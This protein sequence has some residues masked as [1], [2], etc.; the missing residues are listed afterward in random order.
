MGRALGVIA[1]FSYQRRFLITN[2]L[3][4]GLFETVSYLGAVAI[5]YIPETIF[6][7][8]RLFCILIGDGCAPVTSIVYITDVNC[9]MLG[10]S[11]TKW[12]REPSQTLLLWR[13]DN[14]SKFNPCCT[15]SQLRR[16]V[17]CCDAENGQWCLAGRGSFLGRRT[18]QCQIDGANE[19]G[20]PGKCQEPKTN[21]ADPATSSLCHTQYLLSIIFLAFWGHVRCLH[22]TPLNHHTNEV[23][24]ES[25]AGRRSPMF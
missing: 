5:C 18:D 24:E 9:Q 14:T 17:Q 21:N 4:C 22:Q 15:A 2:C 23:T 13:S 12:H 20:T 10:F 19:R 7:Y 11:V 16:L 6:C 25:G 3:F 1:V 8:N